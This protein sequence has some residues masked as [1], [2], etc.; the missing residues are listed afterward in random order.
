MNVVEADKVNTTSLSFFFP[1]DL[2]VCDTEVGIYLI[3]KATGP[4]ILGHRWE[5]IHKIISGGTSLMLATKGLLWLGYNFL[6]EK[7]WLTL[8]YPFIFLPFGI[9]LL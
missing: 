9:A 5:S 1:N 4:A 2:C 8:S 7:R 3:S 6:N